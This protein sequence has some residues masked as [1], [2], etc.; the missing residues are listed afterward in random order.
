MTL[1]ILGSFV[2]LS[3][4]VLCDIVL[5]VTFY[6]YGADYSGRKLGNNTK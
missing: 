6:C 3:I 5:I 4:T 1:S 2:T